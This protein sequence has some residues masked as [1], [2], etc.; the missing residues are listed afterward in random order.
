MYLSPS[1]P[2]AATVYYLDLGDSSWQSVEIRAEG[3][4]IVDYA[5]VWF[6]RPRGF[7]PLPLLQWDGSIDLFKKI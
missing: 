1:G 7:G 3:C 5:P 4:R 2:D 6:R